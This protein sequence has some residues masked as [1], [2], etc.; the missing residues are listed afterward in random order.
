M[1]RPDRTPRS[2]KLGLAPTYSFRIKAK[3][4]KHIRKYLSETFGYT[5]ESI[6]PDVPGL[7]AHLN[8]MNYPA[9]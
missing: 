5:S 8:G 3:A 6:Y 7:V 2:N 9:L 1:S 4:K